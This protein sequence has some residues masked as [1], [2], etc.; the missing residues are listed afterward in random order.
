[1]LSDKTKTN[2]VK[3]NAR[4]GVGYNNDIIVVLHDYGLPSG[5]GENSNKHTTSLNRPSPNNVPTCSND[6]IVNIFF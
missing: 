5:Y 6:N 1:M 4:Y 2:D 3:E